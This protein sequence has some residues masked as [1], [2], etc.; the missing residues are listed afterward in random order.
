MHKMQKT[1]L[2][3]QMQT[4]AGLGASPAKAEIPPER[5]K[6]TIKKAPHRTLHFPVRLFKWSA[7]MPK[8]E[9]IIIISGR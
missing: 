8:A 7:L 5:E 1:I 3:A 4:E 9:N 6:R 2:P